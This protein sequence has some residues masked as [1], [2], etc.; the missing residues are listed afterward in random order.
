MRRALF[1][2]VLLQGAAR[3]RLA[4]VLGAN[5]HD[6][7]TYSSSDFIVPIVGLNDDG[8]CGPFLK[9][10]QNMGSGLEFKK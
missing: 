10:W 4:L 3:V 9:T 7:K 2:P 8:S 5:K 1:L 6:R